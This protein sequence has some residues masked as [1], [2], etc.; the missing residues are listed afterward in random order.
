LI[1]LLLLV[2]SNYL[3][4]PHL[5]FFFLRQ[6]LKSEI[7]LGSEFI[8]YLPSHVFCSLDRELP[9]AILLYID[10]SLFCCFEFKKT[11][12]VELL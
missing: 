6:I 9:Y 8:V 11:V 7:L 12:V 3:K 5:N 1:D 10:S 4:T 2:F